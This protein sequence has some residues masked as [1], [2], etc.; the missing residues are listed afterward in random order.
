MLPGIVEVAGEVFDTRNVRIGIPGNFG[1]LQE[2]YRAP[3]Y[4]VAVG[5]VVANAKN[6]GTVQNPKENGKK[7][8]SGFSVVKGWFKEFF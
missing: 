7:K 8:K 2:E 3:E 4:A 1:G 6:C 5:L